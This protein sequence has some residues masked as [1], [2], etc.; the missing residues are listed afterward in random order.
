MC[1]AL[2]YRIVTVLDEARAVAEGPE[3]PRE[4]ITHLVAP[5]QPGAY[6]LVVYGAAIREVDPDEAAEIRTA[7]DALT[8]DHDA[9]A[10]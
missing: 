3:G 8:V 9:P 4:I 10:P 2:P 5:V 6:V 7:F 1:L